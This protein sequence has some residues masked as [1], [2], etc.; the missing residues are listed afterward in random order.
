M[1]NVINVSYDPSVVNV[2]VNTVRHTGASCP[3]TS[4][5]RVY[6]GMY[7]GGGYLPGIHQGGIYRAIRL[8]PTY[9]GY[10]PPPL[11]SVLLSSPFSSLSGL[12]S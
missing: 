8:L 4:V 3:L 2:S 7:T 1:R 6:T 5:Q 12:L 11:F 10:T 9:L